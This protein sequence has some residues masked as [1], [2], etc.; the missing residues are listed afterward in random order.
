MG[1][2]VSRNIQSSFGDEATQ[3]ALMLEAKSLEYVEQHV[4]L[5]SFSVES[6]LN[7]YIL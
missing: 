7:K 4:R 1:S 6:Q 2:K 5:S 3:C